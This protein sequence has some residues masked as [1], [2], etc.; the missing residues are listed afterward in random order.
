VP[1]NLC[2]IVSITPQIADAPREES[3]AKIGPGKTQH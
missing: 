3:S 2:H 1:T